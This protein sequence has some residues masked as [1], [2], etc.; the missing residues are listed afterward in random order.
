MNEHY[1]TCY[2]CGGDLLGPCA[3]RISD[4]ARFFCEDRDACDERAGAEQ[5]P[6]TGEME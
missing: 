6:Y 5:G 3:C 2:V 1:H 4:P